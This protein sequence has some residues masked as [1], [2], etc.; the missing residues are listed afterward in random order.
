VRWLAIPL[1]R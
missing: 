1:E